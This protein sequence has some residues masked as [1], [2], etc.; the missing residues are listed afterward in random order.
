MSDTSITVIY[1]AMSLTNTPT[2]THLHDTP[3]N[4]CLLHTYGIKHMYRALD[5][6]S[7]SKEN[8]FN[9]AELV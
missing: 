4:T 7:E 1:Y 5:L 8:F 6:M 3:T 9:E 2:T